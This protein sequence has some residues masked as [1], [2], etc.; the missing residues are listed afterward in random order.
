MPSVAPPT[1][2]EFTALIFHDY[3]AAKAAF[4]QE[5]LALHALTTF[6]MSLTTAHSLREAATNLDWH[7][8]NIFTDMQ[9]CSWYNP[10]VINDE[11]PTPTPDLN[12]HPNTIPLPCHAIRYRYTPYAKAYAWKTTGS[13]QPIKRS[14]TMVSQ[15]L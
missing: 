7:A 5:P 10:I 15:E 1:L 8:F 11:D 3:D 14:P 13:K 2:D 6:R 4:P 12:D 9:T